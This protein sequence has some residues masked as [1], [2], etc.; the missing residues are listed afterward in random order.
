MMTDA[1]VQQQISEVTI[2]ALLASRAR[3]GEERVAT[4]ARILADADE[5]TARIE[6]FRTALEER[7]VAFPTIALLARAILSQ[8]RPDRAV[9]SV[10]LGLLEVVKE[11]QR[12][13]EA[14]FPPPASQS[15]PSVDA[16]TPAKAE[17]AARSTP[18]ADALFTTERKTQPLAAVASDSEVNV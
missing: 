9:Y 3:Q 17:E 8:L 5:A 14:E 18:A 15:P 16:A 6:R 7:I 1:T 2:D 10:C 4:M 13:I 12:L 11:C